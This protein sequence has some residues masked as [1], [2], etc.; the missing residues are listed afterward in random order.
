MLYQLTPTLTEITFDKLSPDV[1][2]AG[3]IPAEELPS[4]A[5]HLGLHDNVVAE[6]LSDHDNYRNTV[7][8][9][10]HYSFAIV[11]IVSAE[12]VYQSSDRVAIFLE[13]NL[14]LM[15]VLRDE[16]GSMQASFQQ[17]IRRFKAENVTLERLV[18]ALMEGAI[19]RDA[20]A[21]SKIEF[22]I[23][24]MEEDVAHGRTN[25]HF[26]T[27]IF[28]RKRQL[29]LLQNYYEQLIDLGEDLQENEN[30]IF[31]DDTLHYFI[32]FTAKADRL[33][34]TVQR[35]QG[36][37]NELREAHQAA[38]D[39]SLNSAMKVFSVIATIFL[40]LTLLVGWYGM[41][42]TNMPELEWEYGYF[43]VIAL[44]VLIIVLSLLLF[45]KKKLF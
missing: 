34:N 19:S 9:Y 17:A 15:A 14:F 36:E 6:C 12:D 1:L 26:G 40:P 20:L 39:Y 37:L 2:T 5:A 31:P 24:G 10:E 42:F 44:S 41:N 28:E 33:S 43:F 22:E 4:V 16:N 7:D 45:K 13:K 27:V 8:V 3:I 30:E 18:Y 29:L 35:L 11:N 32:L 21:L 38:M 25:R 23:S